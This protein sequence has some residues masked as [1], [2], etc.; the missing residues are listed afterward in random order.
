MDF[1]RDLS[2]NL[3]RHHNQGGSQDP[4]GG[5]GEICTKKT[6]SKENAWKDAFKP[7]SFPF[8]IK[9]LHSKW[10]QVSYYWLRFDYFFCLPSLCFGQD[11]SKGIK[12]SSKPPKDYL[13]EWLDIS[14]VLNVLECY[15]FVFSVLSP[16]LLTAVFW[17]DESQSILFD[18]YL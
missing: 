15:T 18:Q 8:K 4:K 13:S 11:Y 2:K 7:C 3:E 5:G 10:F 6:F 12:R 1:P 16:S 14:E 9:Y 17:K